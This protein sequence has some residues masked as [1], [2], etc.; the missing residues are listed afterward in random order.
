M[1]RGG[2]V[3]ER[4]L[5]ASRIISISLLSINIEISHKNARQYAK[6]KKAVM[7]LL[8]KHKV[9][10]RRAKPARRRRRQS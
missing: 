10:Q 5:K 7:A 1:V 9:K 2:M 8:R 6:F 4:S 3:V